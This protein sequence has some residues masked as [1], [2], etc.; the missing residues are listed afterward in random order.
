MGRS[1]A[2]FLKKELALRVTKDKQYPISERCLRS[3]CAGGGGGRGGEARH[4][5]SLT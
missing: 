5:L 4:L 3:S 1:P 2:S